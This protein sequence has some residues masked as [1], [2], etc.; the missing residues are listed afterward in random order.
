MLFFSH[1]RLI[2]CPQHTFRKCRLRSGAVTCKRTHGLLS[3][4]YSRVFTRITWGTL[5]ISRHPASQ[6]PA[7]LP[8][9]QDWLNH[10]FRRAGWG[11]RAFWCHRFGIDVELRITDLHHPYLYHCWGWVKG[12]ARSA[13]H[14]F[15]HLHAIPCWIFTVALER[16]QLHICISSKRKLSFR[17]D[18]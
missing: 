4:I 18:W 10:S 9:L 8:T 2:P 15:R 17:E 16:W 14:C 11:I 3:V 13:R 1:A 5:I 12:L 7:S 6:L